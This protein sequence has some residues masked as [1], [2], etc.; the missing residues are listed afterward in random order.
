Q[1]IVTASSCA[2]G[3]RWASRSENTSSPAVSVSISRR[4]GFRVTSRGHR[5]LP[6]L[7]LVP[8]REAGDHAG[9]FDHVSAGRATP[10]NGVEVASA[11]GERDGK[12]RAEGVAGAG[13]VD[14]ARLERRHV[15]VADARAV[16]AER[17]HGRAGG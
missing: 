17:E 1:T 5:R 10:A 9:V 4:T 8:G 14:G 6:A 16:L 2:A 12:S 11:F 3:W 13:R 15:V 7:Q